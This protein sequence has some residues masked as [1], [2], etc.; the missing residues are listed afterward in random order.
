VEREARR[1]LHETAVAHLIEANPFELPPG[2]VESETEAL[3][4]DL[5]R[6]LRPQQGEATALQITDEM[7]QQLHNQAVSR[8]KR[9]L[10][11]E[12]IAKREQIAVEEGD[13]DA[14]LQRLAER[15]EQRIEYIRRQMEQAGALESIRRSI[16][17]DKVLDFVVGRCT[18]TEVSKPATPAP[19]TTSS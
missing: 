1:A 18:V 3:T 4:A 14:D 15:T 9:E 10:L 13:V 12:E 5:Q 8:I 11:I 7:R 2:M 16:M 6:Q 17:S 19:S